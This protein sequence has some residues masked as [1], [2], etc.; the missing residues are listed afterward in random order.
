MGLF[1]AVPAF[2]STSDSH[3]EADLDYRA[4][5]LLDTARKRAGS[6]RYL[7]V[8]DREDLASEALISVLSSRSKKTLDE[9]IGLVS[10]R[11]SKT[12]SFIEKKSRQLGSDNPGETVSSIDFEK[13]CESESNVYSSIMS[14]GT[15]TESV[16]VS[17][18]LNRL[19]K[20]LCQLAL[21]MVAGYT[22]REIASM[23]GTSATSVQRN[24]NKLR[25]LTA[26][27]FVVVNAA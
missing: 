17:D 20:N 18:F 9:E 6:R 11:A 7:S 3:G 8:A 13:R 19:P 24:V 16:V 27:T 15:S 5:L 12:K 1:I 23:I 4:K 14:T 21:L 26:A 2:E 25:E 22:T 10:F